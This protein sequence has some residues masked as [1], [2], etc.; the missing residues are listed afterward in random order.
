M[1]PGWIFSFIIIIFITGCISSRPSSVR[2]IVAGNIQGKIMRWEEKTGGTIGTLARAGG[3][4]QKR[5]SETEMPTVLL[6]TGNTVQ[7]DC[8]SRRLKAELITKSS[9]MIGYEVLLPGELELNDSPEA[10]RARASMGWQ[11]VLS[12]VKPKKEEIEPPVDYKSYYRFEPVKGWFVYVLNF[13]DNSTYKDSELLKENYEFVESY[14][15]F[16]EFVKNTRPQ[17]MIL[18][19]YQT[20]QIQDLV[21][22][23]NKVEEAKRIDLVIVGRSLYS[24][25][26][27][28]SFRDAAIR[29]INV[30]SSPISVSEIQEAVLTWDNVKETWRLEQHQLQAGLNYPEHEGVR[31]LLKENENQVRELTKRES[32]FERVRTF[33][34]E[35]DKE[36]FLL[37]PEKCSPCHQSSYEIWINSRHAKIEGKVTCDVCHQAGEPHVKFEEWMV[38]VPLEK[39]KEILASYP[40]RLIDYKPDSKKCTDCHKAEFDFDSFWQKIKHPPVGQSSMPIQPAMRNEKKEKES[41]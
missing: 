2:V 16:Q 24:K 23:Y 13:I 5:L 7:M 6:M 19:Q 35:K 17:D 29:D 11:Q 38:T 39:Q 15:A 14:K 28:K 1:K 25:I 33:L 4:V 21:D 41:K 32:Y 22:L 40:S 10:A 27:D 30:M 31:D 36:R 3:L 20:S 34:P 12:N 9:M 18:I 37:E 8:E 26:G